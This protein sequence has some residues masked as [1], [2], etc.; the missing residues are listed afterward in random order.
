V[1]CFAE[2]KRDE[3]AMFSNK[4]CKIIF[5]LMVTCLVSSVGNA[6]DLQKGFVA[7]ARGDFVTALKEWKPLAEKGDGTAQIALGVM[8]RNGK[9]VK[10]DPHEAVKW[11]RLAANQGLDDAQYMLGEMY[12]LGEGVTRDFEEGSNWIALAA[13]QGNADALYTQGLVLYEKE[14]DTEKNKLAKEKLLI[15]AEQKHPGAMYLLGEISLNE[16]TPKDFINSYMWFYLAEALEHEG[17]KEALNKVGR[18][19]TRSQIEEAEKNALE[20]ATKK[21]AKKILG[22]ELTEH[23]KYNEG[24]Y[25]EQKGDIRGAIRL[26]NEAADQGSFHAQFSLAQIY[27]KGLGVQQNADLA[28]KWLKKAADNDNPALRIGHEYAIANTTVGAHYEHGAW[29]SKSIEKAKIYYYKGCGLGDQGGC[30]RLK[31]LGAR[32]PKKKKRTEMSLFEN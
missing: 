15:A 27:G 17:A 11:V 28:F 14:G 10:K 18:K 25:L 13:D 7:F 1:V 30:S 21:I 5:V 29:V 6:G 19:L 4:F 23:Q 9:G 26:Y 22:K 2:L 3:W 24:H 32:E 31:A 16:N 12:L 20:F 8:Y